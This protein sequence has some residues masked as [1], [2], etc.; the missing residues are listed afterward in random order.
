MSAD[1]P[2]RRR[3][4]LLAAGILLGLAMAVGLGWWRVDGPGAERSA[5]PPAPTV[6]TLKDMSF[7][8]LDHTGALVGPES[9]LGRPS[10]VLRLYVLPRCLSHH[11][12]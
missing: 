7:G 5:L 1:V 9:L 2:M 12:G 4:G 3:A 8:L 11:V 6:P 10:I